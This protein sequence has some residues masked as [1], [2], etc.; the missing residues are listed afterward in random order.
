MHAVEALSSRKKSS[1][2]LDYLTLPTDGEYD[3]ILQVCVWGGDGQY[4]CEQ[5]ICG[6]HNYIL[7]AEGRREDAAGEQWGVAAGGEGR[8]V[9]RRSVMNRQ[10]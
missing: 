10:L 1:T 7:W 8:K 2:R 5:C 3:Y 6:Q 4:S 9:A